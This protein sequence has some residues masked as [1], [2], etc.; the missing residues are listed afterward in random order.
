MV[1]AIDINDIIR[2]TTEQFRRIYCK[3]IDNNFAI[4]D[5]DITTN[6][7]SD[8]FPFETKKDYNQ[9]R[10]IDYVFELFGRAEPCSDLVTTV[11]TDWTNNT[12]QNLDDEEIPKSIILFS[13]YEKNL[14]IQATLN[15]LSVNRI[16]EREYYFP[17]DS[18]TI[19]DKA[20]IVI[21]AN[22]R[23]IENVPSD[24]FVI[25]INKPYNKDIESK[26]SFDTLEDV[27]RDENETII[28]ILKGENKND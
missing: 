8:I 7:L 5:E 9:F 21:T 1:I 23:L 2:N 4:D 10:Y 3:E 26:F 18:M 6:I 17:T 25:K 16:R 11:F 20:D 13:P 24:K 22:P 14:S 12:L 15:F 28:K 27:I 19:Y